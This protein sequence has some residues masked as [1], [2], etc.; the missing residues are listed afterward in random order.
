MCCL[1]FVASAA[2]EPAMGEIRL[3]QDQVFRIRLI[4]TK[5]LQ[6]ARPAEYA[7]YQGW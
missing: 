6:F 3:I 5:L 2:A 1:G 7:G 4:V